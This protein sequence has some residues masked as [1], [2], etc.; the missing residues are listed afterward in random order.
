MVKNRTQID[1]GQYFPAS[2]KASHRAGVQEP[3]LGQRTKDTSRTCLPMMTAPLGEAR[4]PWGAGLPGN[5]KPIG[6]VWML[7]L[8]Q[9]RVGAVNTGPLCTHT[10]IHK[11]RCVNRIN[12]WRALSGRGLKLDRCSCAHGGWEGGG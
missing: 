6:Q 3:F 2:D 8:C 11:N 10:A 4:R 1:G 12:T 9:I 7:P 5:T